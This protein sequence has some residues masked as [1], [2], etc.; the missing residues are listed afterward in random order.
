VSGGTHFQSQI[1]LQLSRL[2]RW[3]SGLAGRE[4][5]NRN[6]LHRS[7][8]LR[9]NSCTPTTRFQKF[10][11]TESRA[12]GASVDDSPNVELHSRACK[13]YV[14]VFR[15][16]GAQATRSPASRCVD[17]ILSAGTRRRFRTSLNFDSVQMSHLVG[18]NCHGFTP[19]R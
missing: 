1:L 13:F 10:R 11:G 6:G 8:R 7:V 2:A 15:R 14:G 5:S 12:L 18:S 19:L 17:R 4:S 16:A 9:S 3:C